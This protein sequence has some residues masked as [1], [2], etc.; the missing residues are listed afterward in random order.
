[1]QRTYATATDYFDF[2]GEDDPNEAEPPTTDKALSAR[3]RRASSVIDGLTVTATYSTD[4]DGYPTDAAISGAFTE[5][6]CAQAQWFG[7]TDD[8]TGAIS[9]AGPISLGPLSIGGR[10]NSS[11]SST[12]SPQTARIAPEAVQ[13]LRSAGLLNAA[14]R[15]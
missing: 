13:I 1:M 9:A 6:T 12:T 4:E 14:T 7:E 8:L 2:I 5:A 10:S 15:H 3:L 11:A